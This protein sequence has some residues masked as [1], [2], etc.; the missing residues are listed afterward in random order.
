MAAVKLKSL[1]SHKK[2]K[3][4]KNVTGPCWTLTEF[5]EKLGVKTIQLVKLFRDY[6]EISPKPIE[7]HT[8][9]LG[10]S[11]KVYY[12]LKDLNAWWIEIGKLK[13]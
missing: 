1:A 3:K 5:A 2:F 12:S 13:G 4:E 6:P 10:K 8:P 9:T 7:R 11:L